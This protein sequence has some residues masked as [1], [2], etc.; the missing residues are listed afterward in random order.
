MTYYSWEIVDQWDFEDQDLG[1]WYGIS[2]DTQYSSTA[3]IVDTMAFEGTYAVQL[4]LGD[5]QANGALVN[6]NY[7]VEP[8]YV[9]SYNVWVP[10]DTLDEINGLQTFIQINGWQWMDV[11][12]G[13]DD[14]NQGGWNLLTFV[15]S[16]TLEIV[17]TERI[18]VQVT[19][20]DAAG[21]PTVFVDLITVEIAEPAPEPPPPIVIDVPEPP[22][23]VGDTININGSF[24]IGTELGVTTEVP[25]WSFNITA[26]GANA[27][28]EI[29][30]DAQ[31]GDRA[32]R[33]DFGEWNQA[34]DDW[35]VEATNEPFLVLEGDR[36][37]ATVWMKADQ[38]GRIADLYL[39]LPESGGFQRKPRLGYGIPRRTNHGMAG[40]CIPG[41]HGG[42]AG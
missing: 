23:A 6:D 40:V 7:D 25:G 20:T 31:D 37:R 26:G 14:L 29:V 8:G 24:E 35:N 16:D 15:V 5:D 22:H 1:D 27:E 33:V 4:T 38:D 19:G 3:T 11:W 36:I 30:D 2:D 12:Y 32:L 9:I 13:I 28:F 41:L 21:T 18:G 17:S 34:S 42:C 10:V 39:G